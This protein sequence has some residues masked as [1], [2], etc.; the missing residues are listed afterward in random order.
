MNHFFIVSWGG[1]LQQGISEEQLTER[2][3]ENVI[4]VVPRQH[5]SSYLVAGRDKIWT[6]QKFISC[7]KGNFAFMALLVCVWYYIYGVH[8][9]YKLWKR[10]GLLTSSPFL[11]GN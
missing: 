9:F 2:A 7:V 5:I 1:T 4:L 10:K 6:V 8:G 3:S 11:F